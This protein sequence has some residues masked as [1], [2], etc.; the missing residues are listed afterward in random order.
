MRPLAINSRMA[1]PRIQSMISPWIEASDLHRR[2][3]RRGKSATGTTWESLPLAFT[4]FQPD[5][6]TETQHHQYGVAMEP[7]PEPSLILVPA[8]PGSHGP[9]SHSRTVSRRRSRLAVDVVRSASR[10]VAVLRHRRANNGWRRNALSTNPGSLLSSKSC[11]SGDTL[12]R[13]APHPPVG[14]GCSRCGTAPLGNR[15]APPRHTARGAPP[16]RP[17]SVDYRHNRHH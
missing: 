2:S 16:N 12:A 4:P 1:A 13:P 9:E 11:A 14:P 7:R 6:E 17:K 5:Q 8:V 3:R 15:N 10:C